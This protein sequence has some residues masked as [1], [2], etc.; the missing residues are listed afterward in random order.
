MI[1]KIKNTRNSLTKKYSSYN[2]VTK[3]YDV[4]ILSNEEY[5]K[6]IEKEKKEVK[7]MVLKKKTQVVIPPNP[8][9]DETPPKW[10]SAMEERINQNIKKEIKKAIHELAVKN[11]LKE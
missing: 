7:H 6:L 4:Y 10:A 9:E 1:K 2:K 5:D 3:E 11:N 8:G